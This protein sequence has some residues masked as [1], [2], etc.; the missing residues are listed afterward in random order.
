V[1][2]T[3]SEVTCRTPALQRRIAEADRRRSDDARRLL[4]RA[5]AYFIQVRRTPF[6]REALEVE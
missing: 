4:N 5:R 1:A 6:P 3:R 2:H